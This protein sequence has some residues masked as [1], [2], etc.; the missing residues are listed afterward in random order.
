MNYVVGQ[1][2]ADHG[3]VGCRRPAVRSSSGPP[4]RPGTPAPCRCSTPRCG[5]CRWPSSRAAPRAPPSGTS[6]RCASCAGRSATTPSR[7]STPPTSPGAGAPRAQVEAI[8]D[9]A[10]AMGFGGVHSAGVAA[11]AVRDLAEGHYRD[12]YRRLKPLIDEPFLQ[13]T[14]LEYADFV[15]AAVRAGRVAEAEPYVRRLEELAAANGSP[16]A[17][18]SPQRCR[19][20][21]ARRPAS[22]TSGPRSPRSSRPTST[23]SAAAPTCSTA[24]GCAAASAGATPASSCTP[25]STSSSAAPPR[26]SSSEPAAS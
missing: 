22:R 6:S 12:A 16:W 2:R 8:S 1:R 13:V 18:A 3:A 21:V 5:S 20:L 26:P 9:A 17:R 24:S 10:L 7:S 19:A 25:R 15:E 11:L 23:S 4:P 14:P